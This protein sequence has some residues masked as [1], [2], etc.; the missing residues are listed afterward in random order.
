MILLA[1][2]V[3]ACSGLGGVAIRYLIKYGMLAFFGVYDNFLSAV[4]HVSL[5]RRILAPVIGGLVVGPIIYYLAKEAKGH[6]V[7]EVMMAVLLKDGKIRPRVAFVKSIASAISIGSGGSVGREGPIV[8]IGASLGS[9]LAQYFQLDK[10]D[11]S[12]LVACGAAGGIA[13]AI[14]KETCWPS[15]S[16]HTL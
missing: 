5:T 2:I 11:V 12:T 15:P 4:Q 7:P 3:G 9:S 16:L 6:G 1:L 10:R 8:Q 13:A 14:L